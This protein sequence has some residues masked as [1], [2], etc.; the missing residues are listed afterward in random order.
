MRQQTI[1][2]QHFRLAGKTQLRNEAI[3]MRDLLL[4]IAVL[5]FMCL[6]YILMCHLER[7]LKNIS[8]TANEKQR[9]NK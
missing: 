8:W 2:C 7:F 9:K 6:G 1:D 3:D 4:I 5:T